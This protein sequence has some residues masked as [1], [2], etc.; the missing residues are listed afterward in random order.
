MQLFR[1]CWN[2]AVV[3]YYRKGCRGHS[4]PQIPRTQH[5]VGLVLATLGRCTVRC[6]RVCHAIQNTQPLNSESWEADVITWLLTS[7]MNCVCAILSSFYPLSSSHRGCWHP[8]CHTLYVQSLTCYQR[9]GLGAK[10]TVEKLLLSGMLGFRTHHH[11][12]GTAAF[13]VLA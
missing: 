9:A 10:R 7:C 13:H 2:T 6:N 5:S 11:K 1:D 3:N 12:W 8:S 4:P